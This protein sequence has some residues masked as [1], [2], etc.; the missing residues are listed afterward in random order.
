MVDSAVDTLDWLVITSAGIDPGV[1][2]DRT[3]VAAGRSVRPG[4]FVMLWIRA[5]PDWVSM[6]DDLGRSAHT[7]RRL[8][9]SVCPVRLV[10]YI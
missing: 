5:S 4:K 10:W 1:R 3:V 6:L 8:L 7:R 9:V 2:L